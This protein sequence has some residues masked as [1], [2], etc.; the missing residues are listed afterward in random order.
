LSQSE[1]DL[2]REFHG[3]II[4]PVDRN[5]RKALIRLSEEEKPFWIPVTIQR[6]IKDL[7]AGDHVAIKANPGRFYWFATRVT[8][9]EPK[10]PQETPT[11]ASIG[12]T[13]PS[14]FSLQGP[15]AAAQSTP[16]AF[17]PDFQ[18]IPV[19]QV[20]GSFEGLGR[21]EEDAEL[22]GLVESARTQGILHPIVVMRSTG[23]RNVYLVVAGSRRLK[24]AEKAGLK[25]IPA[26][27]RP[28]NLEEAYEFSF[29][30]NIQRLDLSAYEKGRQL[31]LMLTKLP[32]RYP[33]QEA[34]AKRL[35]KSVSWISLNIKAYEEAE[36]LK[37]KTEFYPG[38]VEGLPERGEFYARKIEGLTEF[39]LRE[40]RKLPEEERPKVLQALA[41]TPIQKP[42][43]KPLSARRIAE[44]AGPE[45]I[46]TGEV[47]TCTVCKEKFRLIHYSAG[48]HKLAPEVGTNADSSSQPTQG[49]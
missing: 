10:P 33:N 6:E 32:H 27:V 3:T 42:G 45:P 5:V 29:I 4:Y 25:H 11:S 40:L 9:E 31:K 2:S 41:E 17:L 7:K 37:E 34:L 22:E 46:D 30:E 26:I 8:L 14:G 19:E 48:K 20:S 12:T 21:L 13:A 43:E 39:Q 1:E 28:Y 16:T 49:A 24:A 38:K 35:G 47:W 23:T 15:E 44:K 18:L 36:K